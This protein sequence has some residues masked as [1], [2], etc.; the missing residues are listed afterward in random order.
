MN[1]NNIRKAM[2]KEPFE[3]FYLRLADGCMMKIPHPDFM[4]VHPQLVIVIAEDGSA[5]H[6]D[7]SL[8]ISIEYSPKPKPRAHAGH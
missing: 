8:I 5:S 7:P 4:A 2:D 1:V 3:P 6:L